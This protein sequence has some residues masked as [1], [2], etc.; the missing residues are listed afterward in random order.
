ME[1]K[2]ILDNLSKI[3][4]I[5]R[6]LVDTY[7]CGV[8]FDIYMSQGYTRI[9][10]NSDQWPCMK[11]KV[12]PSIKE[13]KKAIFENPC[14]S[15]EEMLKY[16]FCRELCTDH[17]EKYG[18]SLLKGKA[19]SLCIEMVKKGIANW[20]GSSEY[21]YVYASVRWGLTILFFSSFTELSDYF[22]QRWGGNSVSRYDEMED[23]TLENLYDELAY[24]YKNELESDN[25]EISNIPVCSYEL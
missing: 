3:K 10:G 23:F 4:I 21:I 25:S 11:F 13:F 5:V 9:Y 15:V 7:D 8:E 2:C 1:R 18:Y 16:D 20:E 14:L 17:D 12:T 19:L 6:N 22:F 24:S